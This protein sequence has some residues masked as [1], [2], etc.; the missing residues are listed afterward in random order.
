ME[1]ANSFFV[2]YNMLYYVTNVTEI[3]NVYYN[4]VNNID[5]A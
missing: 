2:L 4:L 1:N 3:L 5:K